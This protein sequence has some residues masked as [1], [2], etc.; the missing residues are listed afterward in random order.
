MF[1]NFNVEFKRNEV[2]LIIHFSLGDN[3]S[4]KIDW[5]CSTASKSE[6]MNGRHTYLKYLYIFHYIGTHYQPKCLSFL[7]YSSPS[8]LVRWFMVLDPQYLKR[9]EGGGGIVVSLEYWKPSFNQLSQLQTFRP[10]LS[11]TQ[12]PLLS[13]TLFIIII[14]KSRQYSNVGFFSL[15]TYISFS[16]IIELS[17]EKRLWLSANNYKE[18]LS[19]KGGYNY[20]KSII[21]FWRI[22]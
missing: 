16:F 4:R 20:I 7:S 22:V 12:T 10:R 14:K 6:Q 2:A 19:G 9:R 11:W 3:T 15:R 5:L 13:I 1:N 21:Y 17:V 18:N 8:F